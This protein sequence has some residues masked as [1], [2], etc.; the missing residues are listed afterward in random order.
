MN[1]TVSDFTNTEQ[2]LMSSISSNLQKHLLWMAETYL[3]L[4]Y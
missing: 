2:Y 4:E 1:P 3:F